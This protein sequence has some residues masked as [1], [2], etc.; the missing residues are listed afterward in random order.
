MGRLEP[1]AM[2]HVESEALG[3]PDPQSPGESE[4][5][6]FATRGSWLPGDDTESGLTL[7]P[8]Q[9]D[10]LQATLA[11]FAD[12]DDA[13]ADEGIAV[14]EADPAIGDGGSGTAGAPSDRS[15]DLTWIY[16]RDV[17]KSRLLTRE[18][19]VAI[20][21]RKELGERWVLVAL[22][23]TSIVAN[24]IIE[25]GDGIRAGDPVRADLLALGQD[26]DRPAG[27]RRLLAAIDRV[28]AARTKVRRLHT[29]MTTQRRHHLRT[30][31]R[32]AARLRR[33]QVELS[34]AIRRIRFG[35][36]A[37]QTLVAMVRAAAEPRRLGGDTPRTVEVPTDPW[38]TPALMCQVVAKLERGEALAAA[39]K[40]EFV[41]ANL[42]LVVSIARRHAN[43]GLSLLD[44]IQE[45][46]IGLMRA[47]DKFEYR[48]GYKFSTYATWWIRQAVTRALSDQVR[49]IRL[50]V[51][52]GE[53]LNRLVRT[54][55]VLVQELGREPGVA[56]LA[57]QMDLPPEKVEQLM[58]LT[59]EPISL[60]TPAGGDESS[61]LVDLLENRQTPCPSN[62]VMFSSLKEE[63]RSAL[64][65]LTPREETVVKMRFGMAGERERTLEEVGRHLAVTRERIRQIELKALHKLRHPSRAR[66]L[67]PFL[68][69]ELNPGC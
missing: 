45:G 37:T 48:R 9:S 47:V 21:R 55:R 3:E 54:S 58:K 8:G 38:Q 51:H 64:K 26:V 66:T 42:R 44:L 29:R 32:A 10:N 1:A 65:T 36:S 62:A 7:S 68:Y 35:E 19:E 17:G 11:P 57:Q 16:L 59:K 12:L 5:Q 53:T 23:R 27:R 31:W 2:R 67:R 13:G 18:R 4:A 49:T 20:A 28:R 25:V 46:N 39:A 63:T 61:R 14:P 69:E 22:S 33:A 52:L 41:E 15:R 6:L 24:T 56:D 60:E 50:P 43:R 40:E 34:Q 30:A